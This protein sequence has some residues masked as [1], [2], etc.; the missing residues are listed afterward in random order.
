[1]VGDD[2]KAM[3]EMELMEVCVAAFVVG[4]GYMMNLSKKIMMILPNETFEFL[5]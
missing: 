3:A 4:C 1:M 2:E 5:Y